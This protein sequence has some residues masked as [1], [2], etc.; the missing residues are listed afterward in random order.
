[1]CLFFFWF[2]NALFFYVGHPK[3]DLKAW[4]TLKNIDYLEY[5]IRAY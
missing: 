2:D 4:I 1:M 5:S 3:L